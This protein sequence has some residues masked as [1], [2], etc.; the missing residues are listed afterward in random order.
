M[1]GRDKFIDYVYGNGMYFSLGWWYQDFL[2]YFI[3][4]GRVGVLLEFEYF[5]YIIDGKCFFC[6]R[7]FGW[8]VS[9]LVGVGY[10][11]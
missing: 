7:F 8:S 3:Y 2:D 6:K 11:F 5:I 9:L 10:K 1:F 4:G